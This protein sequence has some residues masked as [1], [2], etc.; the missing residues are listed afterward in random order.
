MTAIKEILSVLEKNRLFSAF[1]E[2]DLSKILTDSRV[3]VSKYEKGKII[4]TDKEF[5]TA[6]G[7]ILSGKISIHRIG[8]GSKVLLN[9]MSSCDLFGAA[10][11]FGAEA[12]Y[13]TEISASESS[14][15]LFFPAELCYELIKENSDFA[16]RYIEFLSEKIRFLNHRISELSAP[17]AERKLA[18]FLSEHDGSPIPD[19]KKLA[20][21][22]GIGRASLYRMLD[23]FSQSGLIEK[24]GKTVTVKDLDRLKKLI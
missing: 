15:I 8:G 13:V 23:S 12:E 7:V 5:K 24:D 20:S 6:L 4:Y 2:E 9:T 18:K 21:F 1:S 11:L 10:S 22:L 17:S 19:M 3:S 14:S 16:L